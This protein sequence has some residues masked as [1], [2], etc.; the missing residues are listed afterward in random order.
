[1]TDGAVSREADKL[2]ARNGYIS[3]PKAV[4]T[5]KGF[6]KDEK[7]WEEEWNKR[8]EKARQKPP[9]IYEPVP[10]HQRVEMWNGSE[11]RYR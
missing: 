7:E 6:S 10:D 11:F 5:N 1:M 9:A 3:S 8:V 4:P 2:P